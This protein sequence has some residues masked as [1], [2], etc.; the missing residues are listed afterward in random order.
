LSPSITGG[1]PEHLVEMTVHEQHFKDLNPNRK[2]ATKGG[3]VPGIFQTKMNTRNLKAT[4]SLHA[5]NSF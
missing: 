3:S 1:S 5:S 4:S 2:V